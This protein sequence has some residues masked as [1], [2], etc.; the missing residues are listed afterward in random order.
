MTEE[1]VIS[2]N[3][4]ADNLRQAINTLV[5]GSNYT[6]A[7]IARETSIGKTR[8]SQF[9]S[10]SYTGD[11]APIISTLGQWFELHASKQNVM[12]VAP[13]FVMTNIA[14][15][16]I[17]SLRYAQMSDG[18]GMTVIMGAPGVGKS[19]AVKEYAKKP[20]T[21]LVIASPSITGLVGFFY[22]LAMTLGIENAPRRKDS[23]CH[24][25]CNR[26]AGTKGLIV[27]DE[28][29]HLQLEVIEELRVMQQKV[30]VGLALVGNPTIY[31]KMVGDSR[32]VDLSRLES[33]ISKKLSIPKVNAGDI[34]AI[35]TAWGLTTALEMDLINKIAGKRGQLRKLSHTLRYASML[36]Q[37]NNERMNDT[38]IRAAFNELK[39]DGFDNA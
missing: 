3:N 18:D 37:G 12:P 39:Q 24:A 6:Q 20:N 22:E 23:L 35:A 27:I 38:H 14:K 30:G 36:A 9:L 4:N 26:L 21:W 8:L 17:S 28:A 1:N 15:N 29:D 11:N 2:I 25:I 31:G 7:Q 32:K 34:N 13:D 19:V 33:R 16:I 10:N 5:A